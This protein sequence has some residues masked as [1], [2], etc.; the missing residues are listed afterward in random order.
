[1][2]ASGKYTPTHHGIVAAAISVVSTS[3]FPLGMKLG[4]T[5]RLEKN[6]GI[7]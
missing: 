5:K 7:N 2:A 1:M 6:R 4:D 3:F